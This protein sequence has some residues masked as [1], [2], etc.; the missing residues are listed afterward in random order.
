MSSLKNLKIIR[1][2]SFSPALSRRLLSYQ[3][4]APFQ[5][6]L[7]AENGAVFL[8]KWFQQGGELPLSSFAPLTAAFSAEAQETLIKNF[9]SALEDSLQKHHTENLYL[10]LGFVL[11]FDPK[12]P[13]TPRLSPSLLVPLE[14]VS[15]TKSLKI[16]NKLPIIENILLRLKFEGAVEFPKTSDARSGETFDVRKYFSL[17]ENVVAGQENWKISQKGIS[18][19]FLN[20]SQLY[21]FRD[22][23]SLLQTENFADHALFS[24][25]LDDNGFQ[26]RS[27]PFEEK[28]VDDYFRPAE[29]HFIYT[30]DA[31][32][33]LAMMDSLYG[34]RSL[35]CIQAPVG[36]TKYE[37]LANILG[38]AVAQDKKVLVV[39][40]KTVSQRRLQAALNPPSFA[41]SVPQNRVQVL[42]DFSGL[43]DSVKNYYQTLNSNSSVGKVSFGQS[44]RILSEVPQT[45][46][47][48][49]ADS[50]FQGSEKLSREEYEVSQEHLGTLIELLNHEGSKAAQEFF[51][52]IEIPVW[53]ENKKAELGK[54]LDESLECA[55]ALE[56]VVDILKENPYFKEIALGDLI[57]VDETARKYF[58]KNTPSFYQ[59][60]LLS[61]DW[62]VYADDFLALPAAGT[63]WTAYRRTGSAIFTDDAIEENIYP[64]RA[65]VQENSDKTFKVFS[66]KY[67]E[68]KK[69]LLG[70]FKTPPKFK[71]DEELLKQI[72]ALILLQEQRKLFRTMSILAHRLCGEDWAYEKTKWNSFHSKLRWFFPFRKRLKDEPS[73]DSVLAILSSYSA[74]DA[75]LPEGKTLKDLCSQLA[76][77]LTQIETILKFDHRFNEQSFESL[78]YNLQQ[79]KKGVDLIELYIEI[80]RESV[81]L[82]KMGLKPLLKEALQSQNSRTELG[83]AYKRFWYSLQ[84]QDICKNYPNLFSLT[85]VICNKTEKEY[86][87]LYDLLNLCNY[88]LI[89]EKLGKN[90]QSIQ[91]KFY[92]EVRLEYPLQE[93]IFD[94]ILFTDADGISVPEALPICYRASHII[95]A[96]DSQNP[97]PLPVDFEK[98]NASSEQDHIFD[99]ALRQGCESADLTFCKEYRHPALFDFANEEFY[100][101]K[102]KT[103][104]QTS[105]KVFTGMKIQEFPQPQSLLLN[106]IVTHAGVSKHQSLGVIVFSEERRQALLGMLETK[107][108]ENPDIR[109]FFAAKDIFRD[110]YIK[111]PEE[112]VED[113]RDVLFVLAE[114][115]PSVSNPKNGSKLVNVCATHALQ[116]LVVFT[117]ETASF[118]QSSSNSGIQ[119][120]RR[121]LHSVQ[122]PEPLYAASDRLPQTPLITEVMQALADESLNAEIH[123]GYRHACVSAVVRD[124]NNPHRFLVAVE[125]DSMGSYLRNSVAELACIRPQLLQRLGWKV[126]RLWTPVWFLS[127]AEERDHLVTSIAIE[128]SV[129]PPPEQTLEPD[130]T[131]TKK[132]FDLK[133]ERY[134]VE[135]FKIEGT[136]YEKP[137]PELTAKQLVFEMKHYIEHEAP[138]HENILRKRLLDLHHVGNP[139]PKVKQAL[140]EAIALGLQKKIFIQTGH[141]FYTPVPKP[142]PL[143][144]RAGLPEE[145]RKFA[146][147][148]PEERTLLPASMSDSE[149]KEA[150][151]LI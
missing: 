117:E 102:L 68:A 62:D 140:N 81:A 37:T 33:T 126:I 138:L 92:N 120:Y 9:E 113:I 61:K 85:A 7:L 57:R 26:H 133:V 42:K 59:W 23:D 34:N 141:F 139:G 132:E 52:G 142:V 96:G 77:N 73:G 25:L 134:N 123:W 78:F 137:L 127:T 44:M 95:L 2:N 114:A 6:P 108:E 76:E 115:S 31:S 129:A 147:L 112:A 105:E 80:Q 110:F 75:A 116:Q 122:N 86:R 5:T 121:W 82:Q 100:Q 50:V 53:N 28:A 143:R 20:T 99:Y 54:L 87:R 150:L 131:G 40:G 30:P 19:C 36:S 145:E 89:Q 148:S 15:E 66:E 71:D 39:S 144:N 146:Y 58:T 111:L 104:P 60:D 125:D 48:K 106:A 151:G 16:S 103:L 109:D 130:E 12:S 55:A 65:E 79:W 41:Y 32:S 70:L 11:W 45:K 128:Q 22:L 14:W 124:A 38:E 4:Q 1:D 29:R 72:D 43:H 47:Q 10:V 88:Q 56:P 149:I 83:T 24:E 98:E 51:Q 27:S 90:P 84:V 94:L 119:A 136:E 107:I 67:R 46:K 63:A 3:T 35:Y 74:L 64:D 91:W 101:K 118:T 135:R 8:E 13:G 93:N 69:R 17:L 21:S 18:L 49:I 97:A